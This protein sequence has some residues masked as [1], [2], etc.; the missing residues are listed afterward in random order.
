M[1]SRRYRTTVAAGVSLFFLPFLGFALGL[2]GSPAKGEDAV[3]TPKDLPLVVKGQALIV[4]GL[5]GDQDHEQLFANTVKQWNAWLTGT[6]GFHPSDV[7]VLSGNIISGTAL[8]DAPQWSV[9]REAI[10][11]E[12]AR[13]KQTL[14]P[15]ERLW[16]FFLGHANFD[17]EHACFHLPG[18]DLREDEL[19]KLF[20]GIG[21]QEQVFWMTMAES[22]RFIKDLSA[23]GR[24]VIAATRAN[25]E[26]N[27]TEFPHALATVAGRSL[28]DLDFN[29]DHKLALLE[30]YYRVIIETQACYDAD[31]RIP[32]EHAQLDDNGDGI[33]VER[34][35]VA[36][37][38]K[39]PAPGDDGML[40]LSTIL[41]YPSPPPKEDAPKP[42]KSVEPKP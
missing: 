28:A 21:C 10:E 12:A 3:S 19:G 32:T 22:G 4:V 8:K 11:K 31:R 33:G 6:L 38:G 18:P 41:P 30:L 20:A 37:P 35:L 16:V 23:K 25:G 26:D 15:D 7:H 1:L 17:G 36:D 2:P 24:V 39:Q 27:E 34:P 5:P 42:N 14:R 40:S 13:L 9:N 29:N